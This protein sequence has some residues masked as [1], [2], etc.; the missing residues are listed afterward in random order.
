MSICYM[1]IIFILVGISENSSSYNHKQF[2]ILQK[3]FN[4]LIEQLHKYLL[5]IIQGSNPRVRVFHGV[6]TKCDISKGVPQGYVLGPLMFTLY[7]NHSELFVNCD[8][9]ILSAD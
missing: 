3:N 9:M 2:I 7:M 4:D 6:S 8:S 5:L 1:E